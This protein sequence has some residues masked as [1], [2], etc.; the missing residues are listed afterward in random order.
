MG[1]GCSLNENHTILNNFNL[2]HHWS[3][4]LHSFQTACKFTN[5]VGSKRDGFKPTTYLF[6]FPENC[7][8]CTPQMRVCTA[9]TIIK[10]L[11]AFKFKTFLLFGSFLCLSSWG[12]R[13][14]FVLSLFF[15]FFEADF[16]QLVVLNLSHLNYIKLCLFLTSNKRWSFKLQLSSISLYAEL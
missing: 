12:L 7:K 2:I 11:E 4:T 16:I 3:S 5:I 15:F 6:L 13:E 10:H 8:A 9:W 1:F 14:D